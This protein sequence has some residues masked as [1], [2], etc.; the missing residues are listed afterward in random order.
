M[1]SLGGLFLR[2]LGMGWR[3][4]QGSEEKTEK[5]HESRLKRPLASYEG[6]D[7]KRVPQTALGCFQHTRAGRHFV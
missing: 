2:R 4:R 1:G 3:N 7:G 5:M 6:E